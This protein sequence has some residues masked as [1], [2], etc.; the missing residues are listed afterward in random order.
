MAIRVLSS[1][2]KLVLRCL[3]QCLKY[4]NFS[5]LDCV[6][7]SEIQAPVDAALFV[8]AVSLETT[9]RL[10]GE[11]IRCWRIPTPAALLDS[12]GRIELRQ[13]CKDETKIAVSGILHDIKNLWNQFKNAGFIVH[14]QPS[15]TNPVRMST[16]CIVGKVVRSRCIGRNGRW[17]EF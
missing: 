2:S 12:T 11:S 3:T 9:R 16:Q 4:C 8:G 14:K 7:A 13:D 10:L 5:F 17:I 1:E 6:A 15:G